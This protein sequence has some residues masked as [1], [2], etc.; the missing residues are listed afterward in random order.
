[1]TTAYFTF[2]REGLEDVESF[3]W[4]PEIGIDFFA[5]ESTDEG[6]DGDIDGEDGDVDGEDGD[7][8]SEGDSDGSAEG[9]R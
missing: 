3:Y 2:D 8:E 5:D 9:V 6:E 1:M 7:E 4:D